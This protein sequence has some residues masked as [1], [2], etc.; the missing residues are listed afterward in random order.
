MEKK[1]QKETAFMRNKLF[2]HDPRML[3][4]HLPDVGTSWRSVR[5]GK[6]PVR[7]CHSNSSQVTETNTTGDQR[8]KT[9][10][11]QMTH[12]RVCEKTS[13][14]LAAVPEATR[15]ILFSF[16]LVFRRT[17]KVGKIILK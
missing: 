17:T 7:N 5:K 11:V 3:N 16:Y 6:A 15:F 14:V 1:K 10:D 12:G 4:S 9:L 8:A 2:L 13:I